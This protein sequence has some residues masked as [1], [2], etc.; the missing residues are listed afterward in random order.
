[1]NDKVY[2]LLF[3]QYLKHA[4]NG[5]MKNS[6]YGL[7]HFFFNSFLMRNAMALMRQT[8]PTPM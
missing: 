6:G 4:L 5:F 3:K 2:Y 1:M 7:Y 8:D